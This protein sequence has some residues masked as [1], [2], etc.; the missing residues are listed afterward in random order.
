MKQKDLIY[1]L[2]AV[3]ILLVAGYVVYTN[4]MPQSNNAKAEVKV[5]VVGTIPAEVDPAGIA[6]LTNPAKTKDF[7]SPVEFSGLNNAAPFGK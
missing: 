4:L 3:V 6:D 7:S 2:L 1:L 5:D